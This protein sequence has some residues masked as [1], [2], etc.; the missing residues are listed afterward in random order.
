MSGTVYS[1]KLILTDTRGNADAFDR[2]RLSEPKTLFEYHPVFG[3]EAPIMTEYVSPSNATSTWDPNN[4]VINMSLT[5]G[6]AGSIVRQSFEYIPYQPGKS[7]LMLFT[8]VMETG[9]G[10]TNCICR[11]GCFDSADRK[12]TGSR[13]TFNGA[14][15][16]NSNTITF[17]AHGFSEDD[18]V[19]YLNGG[20]T[21]IGGLTTAIPYYIIRT[22]A[23]NVQ[24]ETSL[25]DGT[26][27]LSDGTGEAHSLSRTYIFN[28]VDDV[29]GDNNEIELGAHTLAVG[30]KIIYYN[31]GGTSVSGLTS[32][33]YYYVAGIVANE[34]TLATTPG[35]SAIDIATGTGS[36]HTITP[37]DT[38]S[39]GNG[40]FFELNGSDMYVV[41]RLN[42]V[43]NKVI[44]ASWNVD[45]FDG[46]GP[47]GLTI[48]DWSKAYIFAI[49][50]EWLGVGTVRFG[51]FINGQFMEAHKFN[52]SGIG[53]PSSTAI[54]APYIKLAKLPVRYEITSSVGVNATM[55][56][57][58]STVLSEGGF[59]PTGRI[60]SEG[61]NDRVT[62][63]STT[64]FVPLISV[65]LRE[66]EPYNRA[67]I[68]MININ[69]L[70]SDKR[71][72][73]HFH[74]FSLPDSTALTNPTWTLVD[75]N[76][77]CV[78]YDI[79]ATSF[80]GGVTPANGIENLAGYVEAQKTHSYNFK[81]YLNSPRVNSQ[82]NGTS[83]ILCL[84]GLKVG[85]GGNPPEASASLTW[86]EIR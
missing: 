13:I 6:G 2:L 35:G 57:I 43:D 68:M 30:N 26:I 45:V 11:I 39:Y 31:G 12:G 70:D 7:K 34:I 47:S 75:S 46:T 66:E 79:S 55:R 4:T 54:T 53:T 10:Q 27:T 77:S 56:Q 71:K 63:S 85:G 18:P 52:H 67:T 5:N 8:G 42:N 61:S 83:R 1:G 49:D 9:G 15:A 16:V 20:G 69:L 73:L 58:C 21:S 24:L 84:A 74:L 81:D 19:L 65:R 37:N 32:G 80:T 33:N 17:T 59:E 40:T 78:E 25:G 82:I 48:T 28:A 51:F 41:I 23:N 29:D 38:Y 60:F 3:K 76:N 44:Q 62:I 72:G 36:S 86:L 14:N 22:D 50:Q 64:N